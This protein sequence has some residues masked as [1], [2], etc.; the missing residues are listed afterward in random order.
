[1]QITD[2]K[3]IAKYYTA[4]IEKDSQ[5]TGIFYVGV[6]TTGIFCI[7]TC[8]ARKPKMENVVFFSTT[9]EMLQNGF[10]P[11]K[12]CKPTQ[13][14]FEPPKEVQKAIEL[15]HENPFEKV[16]DFQLKSNN[17]NPE[18]I[19]NW[20]KKYHDMTFQAYQR[21]IRINS[22][23]QKLKSGKNVTDTA[24]DSGYESLSG[25]GYTFKNI[26][27]K[28]P[29]QSQDKTVILISRYT[30]PLGPMFVCATDKGICLL[31]FTDRRMLETEF[32]DLQKRLNG[33]ILAGENEHTK[34]LEKEL[35]E[36]FEG[37]RKEFS[38]PLHTPGTEFQNL[39]WE[40][41]QEIPYG[42]TRSYQEQA[43]R[44]N[45]PSAVRAVASANGHNRISILI[46]CHRVIG[47]DGNLTGYGGGLERKRWLLEH[48]KIH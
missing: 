36:Y 28:A 9:K 7:P 31:E 38:V 25:F 10:R 24:F 44:L 41:L 40:L 16:T 17:L 46:P 22:A 2:H 35:Q 33:V 13:N 14:A 21:M 26:V 47:K 48:E 34:Q 29:R 6:K 45:K 43:V 20:F 15:I 11:C 39:V 5:F 19:R 42:E 32:Q 8:T 3:T 23:F 1:M 12:V 30:S 37:A 4:L 27:G 18:K